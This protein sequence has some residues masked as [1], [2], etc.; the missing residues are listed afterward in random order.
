MPT[1]EPLQI[2][3]SSTS[4]LALFKPRNTEAEIF[5][6]KIH[7]VYEEPTHE[8]KQLKPI[9]MKISQNIFK[10]RDKLNDDL[11]ASD[12]FLLSSTNSISVARQK[13]IQNE[14]SKPIFDK[15]PTLLRFYE[16]PIGENVLQEV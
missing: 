5:P 8:L 13:E 16:K 14:S 12:S 4:P 6:S 3:P 10:Q 7:Q 1:P 15:N 9:V 2:K 11:Q